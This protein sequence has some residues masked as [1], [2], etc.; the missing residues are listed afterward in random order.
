[1]GI[2]SER[3]NDVVIVLSGGNS[4][5]L[6]ETKMTLTNQINLFRLRRWCGVRNEV[7]SEC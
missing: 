4:L 6:S 5:G 1:M 3:I 2:A 7:D